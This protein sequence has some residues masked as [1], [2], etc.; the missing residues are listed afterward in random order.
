[1]RVFKKHDASDVHKHTVKKLHII[2]RTTKDIGESLNTVHEKEKWMI[3]EYLLKV[4]QNI[5]FLSQQGIALC[6]DGNE[7][8]SNFIQLLKLKAN[9]D[10]HIPDYLSRKTDKYISGSYSGEWNYCNYGFENFMTNSWLH[11]E[12]SMI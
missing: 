6:G 1:M 2:P 7:D 9:D 12:W 3:V 10:S 5:C 4:L 11:T 8:D